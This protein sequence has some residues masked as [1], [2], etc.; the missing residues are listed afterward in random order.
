M[1]ARRLAI[2]LTL[3]AL[4]ASAAFWLARPRTAPRDAS[5]G[6]AVLSGLA[7]RLD[8]V[9]A[10][11]VMGAAAEPLVTLER[12][13][14]TWRVRESGYPADAPRV[15]RLLVALG[16]LKV[17]EA[18]TAEPARYAAL[19][20]EE[21]TT[22]GATSVRLELEG[23][24]APTGLIV[25]H[26]AGTQGTFVRV[27]GQ[28]QSFE[29]RPGVEVARTPREWLA[30][31]FLDLAAARVESVRVERSGEPAW[32]AQRTERSAAHFSVPNLPRGAEL[33]N[34]GAADSSA[35]AFGNLE[36]DDVRAAPAATAGEKRQR[37]TVRCSDGLVVTLSASAAGTEHWLAL[38][39]RFDAALA[40]R[41][42]AGAPKDAP[43]AAE[44]EKQAAALNVTAAGHE[45]RVP[46][47]RFDAIFRPRH[48]LLR[49]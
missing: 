14:G 26:A 7:G 23:L 35:S 24:G 43:T 48:E 27:A 42:A 22:P 19:G 8:A 21:P 33:T 10:I 5:V 28:A 46:A 34:A 37:T 6:V 31:G 1:T 40:A 3:A 29:G 11:R 45:Y 15:K 17:V 25:G 18:K 41:F 39:A 9:S 4:V 12:V 13:N 47:Y 38:E 44:V 32:D 2:L 49:H 30:R 36:F 20:V 16:E